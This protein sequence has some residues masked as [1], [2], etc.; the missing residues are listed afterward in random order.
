MKSALAIA[1]VFLAACSS[2]P[3]QSA[4]VDFGFQCIGNLHEV[5]HEHHTAGV[6]ALARVVPGPHAFALGPLENLNGEFVVLDDQIWIAKPGSASEV[7]VSHSFSSPE[8]AALYVGARVEHWNRSKI[9]C[10]TTMAELEQLLPERARVV[11][12]DVDAP[13][14]FRVEGQVA[15]LDLHVIDGRHVVDTGDPHEDHLRASVRTSLHDVRATV[16][17]FHSFSGQGVFTHSGSN[18]H[19]HAVVDEPEW[20]GHV[21][22]VVVRSGATL[23]LPAPEH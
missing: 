1:T 13:F 16:L 8:S 21:D 3:P 14:P 15:R 5:M 23:W 9:E 17:G 22:D 20:C 4:R 18:V 19:M 12:I 10:D 6:V 7:L 2:P 11:G